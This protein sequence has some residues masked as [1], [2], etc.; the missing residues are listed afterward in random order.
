[1][2]GASTPRLFVRSRDGQWTQG[3]C[4]SPTSPRRSRDGQRTVGRWS[5]VAPGRW[6]G[7]HADRP[8]LHEHQ[9]R[10]RAV[11]VAA[12][13]SSSRKA[14]AFLGPARASRQCLVFALRH[15][16]TA[17]VICTGVGSRTCW[18]SS[19][20]ACHGKQMVP[21][22]ARKR[23]NRP[24]ARHWPSLHLDGQAEQ[25]HAAATSNGEEGV[26]SVHLGLDAIGEALRILPVR[27]GNA[28]CRGD[29][30]LGVEAPLLGLTRAC[31]SRPRLS[32]ND[33][34]AKS[35]SNTT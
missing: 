23:G 19:W 20:S 11:P 28:A 16:T 13:T 10:T 15:T 7:S 9:P 25:L 33:Q 29:L 26:K 24:L 2:I 12:P 17:P 5:S 27:E 22:S 6:S 35:R 30:G 21:S 32:R 4:P 3:R 14:Y 31:I 34:Q 8:S 1:M 18:S